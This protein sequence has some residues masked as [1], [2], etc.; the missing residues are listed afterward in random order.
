[1]AHVYALTRVQLRVA[2]IRQ[3]V[4]FRKRNELLELA[5][6]DIIDTAAVQA[7]VSLPA[8][9]GEPFA[10][11]GGAAAPV[12]AG[13]IIAAIVAWLQ[14]DAGKALINALLSLL[15]GLI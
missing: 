12:A 6:D 14:S 9:E 1:M 2:L 3:G 10:T 8:E 5:T 11:G 13:G 7:N 15:L 4:P